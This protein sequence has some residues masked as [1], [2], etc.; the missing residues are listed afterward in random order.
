MFFSFRVLFYAIIF[1]LIEEFL[2]L[3]EFRLKWEFYGENRGA[4]IL[5]FSLVLSLF[6]FLVVR[7]ISGKTAATPMAVIFSFSSI[8][9]YYLIDNLAEKQIFFILSSLIFYFHVLGHYRLSKYEKDAT[10]RGVIAA[11]LMASVFIFLTS[12]YGLYLNFTVPQWLFMLAV[13]AIVSLASFSYFRLI[14][15]NKKTN[16][17]YSLCIGTAM[18]QIAWAAVFW[19]FGYLTTGVVALML[20]YVFWDMTQ[21]NFLNLLSKKRIVANVALFSVLIALVLASSRW[22]PAI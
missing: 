20:Y 5:L 1:F 12:F 16:W 8:V 15:E 22:L 19:P 13:F 4:F 10:A 9:L 14:I 6:A 21:S 17:L 7:K 18:A 2:I 11:T 3:M